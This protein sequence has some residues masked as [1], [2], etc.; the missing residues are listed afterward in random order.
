AVAQRAKAEACPPFKATVA[1]RWW[2]RRKR[3][4][5]PYH[6]SSFRDAPRRFTRYRSFFAARVRAGAPQSPFALVSARLRPRAAGQDRRDTV[7]PRRAPLPWRACDG[8]RQG[9]CGCLRAVRRSWPSRLGRNAGLYRNPLILR[10]LSTPP[11]PDRLHKSGPSRWNFSCAAQVAACRLPVNHLLTIA[12]LAFGH[13][14]SSPADS[15]PCSFEENSRCPLR[16]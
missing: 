13:Y 6:P 1:D 15:C 2:A 16:F 8:T 3:L 7:A 5:P 12:V 9:I 10:Q 11:N 4:C 14:R